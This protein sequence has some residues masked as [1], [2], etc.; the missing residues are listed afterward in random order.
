MKLIYFLL[1]I[2]P[3]LP[4]VKVVNNLYVFPGEVALV[5][6]GLF[7]LYKQKIPSFL[8]KSKASKFLLWFWIV[9]IFFSI[10][11]FPFYP[12]PGDFLRAI[13]GLI[14]VPVIYIGYRYRER[15]PKDM[16]FYGT[17]SV[18]INLTN[19]FLI[20]VPQYG[21][22]IWQPEALYSGFSNYYFDFATL[23]I[24]LI[25]KG[26]HGVYGD[27][28]VLLIAISLYQIARR[29]ISLVAGSGMILL[30]TISVFLTVSRGSFFT[31]VF[32][33]FLILIW[34]LPR[35]ANILK[36]LFVL[37]VFGVIILSLF[38]VTIFNPN[39]ATIPLIQKIIYTI[40]SYQ[41]RGTESNFQ[42]R[43]GGWISTLYAMGD[44]PYRILIG[45]G[46]NL[47]CI[48]DYMQSAAQRY[49]IY[50]MIALPESLIFLAYQFGGM[51]GLILLLLFLISVIKPCFHSNSQPYLPLFGIY[52]L[53]LLPTNF[54]SG[55]SIIADLLYSQILL[56]IGYLHKYDYQNAKDLNNHR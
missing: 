42:M 19:Y 40:D 11:N 16:L 49:G 28:S 20:K 32:F 10:L 6:Y 26:A 7:L 35:R 24:N 45:C 51:I 30:F 22:E 39:I 41:V 27:Y 46:Y 17:L 34:Y 54:F 12:S 38:S 48:K 47:L 36:K 44:Y 2:T 43:I 33:W 52:F 1:L 25:P 29:E 3:V 15:L 53:A 5:F 14:Y 37:L 4:K 21:F 13:K 55:A 9:M 56:V 18:L 50:T 8:I 23:T 31:F